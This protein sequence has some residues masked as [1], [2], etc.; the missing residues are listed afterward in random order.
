M[1]EQT[2]TLDIIGDTTLMK[3]ISD[4]GKQ[5]LE[6]NEIPSSFTPIKYL[7]P[8][9][10]KLTMKVAYFQKLLHTPSSMARDLAMSLSLMLL[11]QNVVRYTLHASTSKHHASDTPSLQC[12]ALQL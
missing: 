5:P 4:F 8:Y 9:L 7:N 6:T 1:Q 10:N 2:L 12:H 11:T 3:Y